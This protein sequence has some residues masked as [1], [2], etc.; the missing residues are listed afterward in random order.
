MRD[1]SVVTITNLKVYRDLPGVSAASV[2]RPESAD[3]ALLGYE[4]LDVAN[5]ERSG[6]RYF[7][8]LTSI[9]A[10]AALRDPARG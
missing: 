8:P 7:T 2:E 1:G 4:L 6:M 9:W 5:P 10:L 3:R